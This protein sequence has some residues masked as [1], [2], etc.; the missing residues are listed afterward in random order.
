[1][2]VFGF[3]SS[4]VSKYCLVL[5]M[6]MSFDTYMLNVSLINSMCFC[7]EDDGTTP[8]RIAQITGP[9]DRCQHAAEIIT[10]L[11]R[12]VQVVQKINKYCHMNK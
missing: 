3:S 2:L 11:L 8:D 12:S 5:L 7:F 10:D 6:A 1:M 4:Q 9:P